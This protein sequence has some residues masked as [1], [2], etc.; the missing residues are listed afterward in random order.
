M[1]MPM[2]W[3]G[4]T[5]CDMNTLYEYLCCIKWIFKLFYFILFTFI[6]HDINMIYLYYYN[7]IYVILFLSHK[8]Q[9]CY[10]YYLWCVVVHGWPIDFEWERKGKES[11]E[12]NDM[13][14][15][16]ISSLMLM[17]WDVQVRHFCVS[18]ITNVMYEILRKQKSNCSTFMLMLW[19][20]RIT[21]NMT[22]LYEYMCCIKPCVYCIFLCLNLFN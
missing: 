19:D 4:R 15:L 20:R 10:I 18:G 13:H 3:D 7:Y 2:L 12:S 8:S 22:T 17:L 21:S 1:F 16:Y 6:H 9:R 11:K 5:I 14:A